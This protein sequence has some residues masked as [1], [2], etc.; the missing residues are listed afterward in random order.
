[1]KKKMTAYMSILSEGDFSIFEEII[2]NK[3]RKFIEFFW[4]LKEYSDNISALKYKDSPKNVL[5]IE[6]TMAS[7]NI[8]EVLQDMQEKITDNE[9]I[10]IYNNGK[11]INIEIKKEECEL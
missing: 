10:L 9:N 11:K 3:Y 1:M 6:V 8:D 7:I 4:L 2:T 5:K